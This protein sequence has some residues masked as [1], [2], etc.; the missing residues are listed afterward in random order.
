MNGIVVIDKPAGLTSHDVVSKVKKILGTRK[1]G[2]TGTL[3]PM[4]TGVLPVCL[5]EATKLAQFLTAENKTYRATMLLGIETNTQDIEGDVIKKSD[6]TVSEEEIRMTLGRFVGKIKQ[7]PPAFSALKHK[8]RPLYQYAREGTF[9]DVAARDVEIYRLEVLDIS[10][11]YVTFET[12]CSKGTY[13]RTICSDAGKE[14]GCGAC[15]SGLRR[16]RSGFFTEAMAVTLQDDLS[17]GKK[18]ELLTKMLTMAES[19]PEFTEIKVSEAMAEK[20]KNGFQPDVDMMRPNVL[21]FLAVGDMVKFVNHRG[22]LVAVAEMLLP[23][24]AMAG[25][26]GKSQAARMLRVF[27]DISQ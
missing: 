14:M 2:H 6:R 8:G 11:P 18:K 22:D 26:D 3:D 16:L 23:Q 13:V 4:A 15:L 12:D 10:Y 17:E 24:S 21:P 20:L 9:P 19:L 27:N 7:V 1:A 25:Q 5:D